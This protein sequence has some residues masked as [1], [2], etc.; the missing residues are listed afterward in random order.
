VTRYA[1]FVLLLLLTCF[2][3]LAVSQTNPA[4]AP[5]GAALLRRLDA[6]DARVAKFSD[7][8]ADFRQE[9]FTALLRKP[10]VSTGSLRVKGSLMRWDTQQPEPTVMAFT[11]REVHILYPKQRAMET[12]PINQE[13]GSLAANPIPRLDVL[14]RYF[15]IAQM[16]VS[17]LPRADTE[18]AHPIALRL[19]PVDEALQQH[20]RE[21]HVLLDEDR[22]FIML[23]EII[24][25]DGDRTVMQFSN[26]RVDTNLR[27]NDLRIEP[28]AGT[29]VSRPLDGL[30]PAD[31]Q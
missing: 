31:G 3:P 14:K 2:S 27:D 29:K 30:A 19:T 8:T 9:K 5:T 24:D 15:S 4:T 6:I 17:Q 21:V 10:L 28:P 12:Y 1:R 20:V 7:L 16:D 23:A 26:L 22:G 13:L 11:D 25:A 18:S